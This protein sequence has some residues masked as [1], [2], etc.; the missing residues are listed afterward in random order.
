[1]SDIA[2]SAVFRPATLVPDDRRSGFIPTLFGRRN[3]F[4]GETLLY[5]FMDRLSP[6]YSGG[7]WQFYKAGGQPLYLA[8][9]GRERLRICCAANG[10]EGEVS[11]DAAGII[12]TLFTF[13]HLSFE[14]EDDHVAEAFHRLRDHALDHPEAAEI[15]GAID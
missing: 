11:A 5:G 12:A 13:S 10:Y 7:Y 9:T 2:A 6:D 4:K 8:P 3:F 15:F 14:V 1:M